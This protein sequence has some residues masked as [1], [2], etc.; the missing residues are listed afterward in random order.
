MKCSNCNHVFP[1]TWKRY[2]RAPFGRLRCPSCSAKLVG[3]HRWFYWPLVAFGACIGGFPL[4]YLCSSRVEHG[5]FMG[6]IVGSI[7][8]GIP[9]DKYLESKFGIV[10][11]RNDE[12]KLLK[13]RPLWHW[14]IC[15]LYIFVGIIGV[16]GFFLLVSGKIEMDAH[17]QAYLDALTFWK[18][19][20]TAGVSALYILSGILLLLLQRTGLVIF[21]IAFCLRVLERWLAQGPMGF[22]GDI[23]ALTSTKVLAKMIAWLMPVVLIIVWSN[24]WKQRRLK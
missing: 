11:T 19:I 15:S 9:I 21:V 4:A 14:I 20:G 3:R 10:R 17:K 16:V 1:L 24:W 2:F 12:H 7:L 13:Q 8:S 22:I 18:V 23:D 5:A 6:W